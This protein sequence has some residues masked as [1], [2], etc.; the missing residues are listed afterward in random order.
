M[1]IDLTVPTAYVS[2]VAFGRFA[3]TLYAFGLE[4]DPAAPMNVETAGGCAVGWN[5]GGPVSPRGRHQART[6]LTESMEA[7]ARANTLDL[8]VP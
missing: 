1:L 7:W 6:D 4:L 3:Y 5:C 2:L 8:V